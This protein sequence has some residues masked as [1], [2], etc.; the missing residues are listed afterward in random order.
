MAKQTASW[1]LNIG[2]SSNR[3][4]QGLLVSGGVVV[5]MFSFIL[6]KQVLHFNSA[7]L[8]E[9]LKIKK[10]SIPLPFLPQSWFSGK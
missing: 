1:P 2:L 3:T 10:T 7:A 5:L 6:K 4:F 9:H 8:V